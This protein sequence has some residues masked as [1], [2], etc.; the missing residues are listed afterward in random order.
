MHSL[1]CVTSEIIT[2][3]FPPFSFALI[4]SCL[5]SGGAADAV[6]IEIRSYCVENWFIHDVYT[7]FKMC[8]QILVYTLPL[9][10]ICPLL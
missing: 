9:G 1:Q 7:P 2:I 8:K 4:K 10:S 3:I 5:T 6:E